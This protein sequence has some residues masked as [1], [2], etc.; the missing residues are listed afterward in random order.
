[1]CAVLSLVVVPWKLQASAATFLTFLGSYV[2]FV[3]PLV[4][5]MM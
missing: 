3:S 4:A 1:M 2:C 5:F